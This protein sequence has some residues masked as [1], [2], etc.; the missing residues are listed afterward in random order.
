MLLATMLISFTGMEMSAAHVNEVQNPGRNYPR[1]IFGASLIILF[2]SVFGSLSIA[3]VMPANELSMSSGVCEALAKV[4]DHHHMPWVTSTVSLLMAYGALTMVITWMIGPSKG[5][6]QVAREGFLP[7]FWRR[8]NQADMPVNILIIQTVLAS[9]FSLVILVLPTVSSAFIFMSAF[10]AQLYLIMY[11]LMFTAAI[12]LRYTHPQVPRPYRI[13]GGTAGMWV[14]A[15]TGT[16]ASVF[17]FF[18]GFIPMN[19]VRAEGLGASIAYAGS[20]LAGCILLTAV[21]LI[22]YRRATRNGPS[23]SP[24]ENP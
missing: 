22:F 11:L 12:R 20:L 16:L 18:F 13:P 5:L 4:F 17:V 24:Q 2:L 14:V 15:G 1:A 8:T 21:P 23:P 7:R 9:L 19:A 3:L 10:A 6:L